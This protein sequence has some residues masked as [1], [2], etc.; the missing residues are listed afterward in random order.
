M[1]SG[2][3]VGYLRNKRVLYNNGTA[4]V[5]DAGTQQPIGRM[6]QGKFIPNTG[7]RGDPNQDP[8]NGVPIFFPPNPAVGT[9]PAGTAAPPP[10]EPTTSTALPAAPSTASTATPPAAP[11]TLAPAKPKF[12]MSRAKTFSGEDGYE[13]AF[14]PHTNIIAILKSPH[15]SQGSPPVYVRPDGKF[16]DAHKAIMAEYRANMLTP[17]PVVAEAPL[18]PPPAI[19]KE[20]PPKP[21]AKKPRGGLLQRVFD[22]SAS[23]IESDDF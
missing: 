23:V 14:D 22:S 19:P 6:F 9:G 5:L 15:R 13:Y 20:T 4:E 7:L 21:S 2:F 8:L 11:A 3:S 10:T 17:K 1:N 16:Q 12:S 18:K